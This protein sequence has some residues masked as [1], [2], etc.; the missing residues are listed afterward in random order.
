M[1]SRSCSPTRAADAGLRRVMFTAAGILLLVLLCAAPAAASA[2]DAVVFGGGTFETAEKLADALGSGNATADGGT[3]TL[4]T[5]L[6]LT[7]TIN[8]TGKMTIL[9]ADHTIWRGGK[10][11]HLI[12]VTGSDGN[13]TLGS[14][15]TSKLTVDGQGTPFTGKK[16]P[17]VVTSGGNLTMKSG[18]NLTNSILTEL[19]AVNDG[20]GVTVRSGGT[21]TMYGGEIS[22]NRVQY[23]TGGV[24]VASGGTFTM[25]G[26]EISNN[27]ITDTDGGGVYVYGGTFTMSGG[28][29]SDNTAGNYAGGVYVMGGTFTMSGGTISDNAA[30]N[31][32]GGVYMSG[33]T[34]TL[35][36]GTISDNT[37]TKNGGGVYVG[38]GTFIMNGSA[39]VTADNDVYLV[40]GKK[41]TVNGAMSGGGAQN[42]THAVTTAGTIVVSVDYSGGTAKSVKQYFKLNSLLASEQRIG[43]TAEGNDLKIGALVPEVDDPTV[44]VT[45]YTSTV[46]NVSFNLTTASGATKVYVNLT[47]VSGGTPIAT[48]YT[49]TISPGMGVVNHQVPGLTAGTAY[50]LNI[51][52][53][54]DTTEGTLFTTTYTAPS[55]VYTVTVQND[56]HG[57]GSAS[58]AGGV[59]G[60]A[61]TLTSSPASGYQFK[62]WQVVQGSVSVSGNTFPM[63]AE[64]VILKALF[65]PQTTPTPAPT[66]P[67]PP[68]SGDG[69]GFSS[70]DSGSVSATGQVSFGT[71][72]GVTRISFAPG[73]SGTV[74]IDTKPTGVTPPPDSYIVI[75]ITGPAFEG[76]AQIEFSVPVALLTDRG[77][78]VY[79]VSLRHFI[80]GK[81]VTLRTHY[82]GEER[83]AAN[84]I[85]ATQ[86]FSP[87]AI[88]YE[89]GGAEIIESATPEPTGSTTARPTVQETSG[90]LRPASGVQNTPAATTAAPDGGTPVP[91]LTQAP[92]PVFGALAGLLAA[93]V[94]FRRRE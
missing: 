13:L 84:Y 53:W 7:G 58:P 65:E 33:G 72:T 48:Q 22:N 8:I 35:S 51:T 86:T 92:A 45:P 19:G 3:L 46:A 78:T 56:G 2:A 87:F 20:G 37:A 70:T 27:T 12:N 64:N 41:I 67:R 14:D 9:G 77:L 25:Y 80:G 16:G 59:A 32:G 24:H 21:F 75:D 61:I 50:T 54:N 29:I 43:L 68:S 74:T 81:W 1:M 42:I 39:A 44:F 85:A 60:T 4:L 36:G 88:V 63:P 6:N 30:V 26:G 31:N 52:P 23:G 40:S 10:D 76:Y 11:F 57:T 91:T 17:I 82:L 47:P 89:K 79:D 71:T 69:G 28:T 18:V 94:L 38:G 62:A 49:G 5:D 15:E 34:L 83:G 90:D 66:Q 93:G 55:P 73:T